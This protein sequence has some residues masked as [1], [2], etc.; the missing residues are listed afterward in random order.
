MRLSLMRCAMLARII[1]VLLIAAALG[2]CSTLRLAYNNLPELAYWWLDGYVDFDEAQSPRVRE[3]LARLQ[4]WHRREELPKLVT[5]LQQAERM[6]PGEVT[7]EQACALADSIRTRL[8]AV[9]DHAEAPGA[10]LAASLSPAQ[11]DHLARKYEKINA[12]YAQQWL[13]PGPAEQQDKR[14][15]QIRERYEDFY[16][17][18]DADQR[19]LLR[20][21]VAESSF[22]PAVQD[23]ARR[24][25]Q[26]QTLALLGRIAGGD[27]PPVEARA[28]LHAYARQIADAGPGPEHERQQRV[29]QETCRDFAQLHNQ[30]T[31]TQREQARKR[32]QGYESDLDR[33]TRAAATPA[34][35]AVR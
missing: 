1:G 15:R 3:Q 11:L 27:M 33:L 22:D 34:D 35:S 20:R 28:A 26:Q 21:Q 24:E 4:A 17:T 29:R 16:G 31:P 8:L 14:A 23:A 9:A 18:L 10:E 25:R 12:E 7:S 5:L 6:V 30:T 32:L 2:A 19:E 13:A